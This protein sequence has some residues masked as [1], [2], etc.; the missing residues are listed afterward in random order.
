MAHGQITHIEFPADDTER[1]RRFYSELFG[2]KLTEW[3]EFPGYFVFSTG[4]TETAGGAIGE[5][6]KSVGDKV[7]VYIEVDSIDEV[8]PRVP[9]LG[10]KV[11]TPRTAIAG[12]GW[13]AVL[14]D[15]EGSEVALYE[16]QG[17]P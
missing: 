12:Q 6:G 15:S 17:A 3:P 2:W 7:R 16:G 14:N 10:G 4:P 8:V 11:I 9:D 1:A 13:Y 5:R